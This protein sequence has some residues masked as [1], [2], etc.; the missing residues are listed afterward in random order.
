MFF[1]LFHAPEKR[2]SKLKSGGKE[3]SDHVC[4]SLDHS[5]D[6]KIYLKQHISHE[7]FQFYVGNLLNDV[8]IISTLN[9]LF[10]HSV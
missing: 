3:E 10:M 5:E 2:P 8:Y 6:I 9:D 4:P 1:V 7:C